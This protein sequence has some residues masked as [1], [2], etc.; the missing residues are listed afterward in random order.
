MVEF[1]GV[2][3]IAL[4]LLNLYFWNGNKDGFNLVAGTFALSVGIIILT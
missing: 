2:M 1:L 3:N 4:G